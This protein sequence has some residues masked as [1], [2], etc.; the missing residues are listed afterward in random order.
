MSCKLATQL[1]CEQTF[2]DKIQDA[3]TLEAKLPY[4]QIFDDKIQDAI[5]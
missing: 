3:I 1:P 2:D 5:T 4:E